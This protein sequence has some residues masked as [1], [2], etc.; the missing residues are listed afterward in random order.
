MAGK[1]DQRIGLYAQPGKRVIGQD[2]LYCIID[3]VTDDV[4]CDIAGPFACFDK[5]RE[6]GVDLNGIEITVQLPA[7]R[8]DK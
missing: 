2:A 5:G 8:R 7:V 6:S 1:C 4:Q 3:A